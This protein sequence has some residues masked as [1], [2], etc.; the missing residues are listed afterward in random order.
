MASRKEVQE[1]VQLH[2]T[3]IAKAELLFKEDFILERL[4]NSLRPGRADEILNHKNFRSE[5]GRAIRA[6]KKNAVL[7]RKAGNNSTSLVTS[8]SVGR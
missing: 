6:L 4:A 5:V 3:Y 8:T 1:A 7:E 2:I